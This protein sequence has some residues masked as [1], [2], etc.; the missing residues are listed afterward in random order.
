VFKY[1]F[2]NT[3]TGLGCSGVLLCSLGVE[4]ELSPYSQILLVEER[5]MISKHSSS[6]VK[7][8]SGPVR[9]NLLQ[10]QRKYTLQFPISGA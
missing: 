7:S 5:L 4:I 6:S 3:Q 9:T 1:Y 8:T 10:T 2:S